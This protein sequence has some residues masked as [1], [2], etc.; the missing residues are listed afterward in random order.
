MPEP[1]RMTRVSL[2]SGMASK[3]VEDIGNTVGIPEIPWFKCTDMCR[4]GEGM[5]DVDLL[6]ECLSSV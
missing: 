2:G 5:G 1:R 6:G 3:V 4:L